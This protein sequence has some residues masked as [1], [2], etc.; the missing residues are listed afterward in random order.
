MGN[1]AVII[2]KGKPEGIYL[3]WNGGRD[4]VE[5]I[6]YYAKNFLNIESTLLTSNLRKFEFIALCIGLNPEY[7]EFYE[8]LDCDNY[9][10]G[11]YVINK[12]YEIIERRKQKH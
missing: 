4:S 3:H 11:V 8:H 1:R 5:P 6:L 10:N 2:E 12:D 7:S 9:D